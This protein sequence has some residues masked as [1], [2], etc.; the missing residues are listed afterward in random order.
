VEAFE[1]FGFPG[2]AASVAAPRHPQVAGL[3]PPD[4]VVVAGD[5]MGAADWER[6][7]AR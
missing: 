3:E 6:E 5:E 7:R 1:E 2:E 4:V